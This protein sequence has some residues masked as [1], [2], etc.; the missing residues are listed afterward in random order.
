MMKKGQG[1]SMNVIIVAAIALVVLVILVFL[2]LDSGEKT[3]KATGCEGT[4]G[5]CDS[6]EC[7]EGYGHNS[8][9]DKDCEGSG[10]WCCVPISTG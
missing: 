10:S 5:I 4:G 2:L 7:P 3:S 8:A 9:L 6:G 1:I